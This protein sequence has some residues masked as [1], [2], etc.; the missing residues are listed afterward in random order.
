MAKEVTIQ[1]LDPI[2]F[3]YQSYSEM[4]TELIVQTNVE[5]SFTASTDYIEYYV[6]DQNKNQIFPG[7]TVPLLDFQIRQGDILLDPQT[8]LEGAG[9]DLGIYNILYTFYRKRLGSSVTEKYF[10]SEISSDR[11]E[12][13][14]DSNI[15]DNDLIISSSNEFIEFREASEYFVDFYLNFGNNETVIANNLR[16]ETEEGVDPTVLIKLYD[17]LP[18]NFSV[19]DE[20]WVVEQISTPQAYE[21]DFPFEPIIEEDFTYIAGPNYNLNVTQETSTGGES[22]SFSSLLQSDVTSSI[23]QIKNLLNQKEINININYENYSNFVHFSSAKT[24]LE[25]FYYKVGLIESASNLLVEKYSATGGTINTPSFIASKA[26]VTSEI[27]NIIK[28]FDGYESFLYFNSGSSFSYPKITD[29]PPYQLAPTGSTQALE[30]IGNADPEDPYY[31]GQALSASNFDEN[32]RNYLFNSIPEYLRDDPA[33]QGYELF[34]DMVAQYYDNVWIYTKD[35]SNKFDADNRLEFG[36]SKDLVADAIRDFGVKLYASSFNTN[37]LFTAFLGITPSGSTFPFPNMTGSVVDGSGN[38][39]IPSGFEFVD[40]KISASNDIVP[41]NNVQKQLYKRIYHNIPYLLKTKGTV[42]G[43]RALITSYG[44][45]DTIL[46]INEFGGKDRN[47]SQDYDLKQDVFNYAF[48]TGPSATNYVSSSFSPNPT[49]GLPDGALNS[50]GTVQFRFK[51]APIP[52]ASS[53]VA[54]SDI[55]YSQSLWSTDDGGNIMLEYTGSG[56]V[57]GSYSGSAVNPYDYYGTLKFVPAKGDN[58]S[59]SASIFLP[60][61]NGDWWSVQANVDTNGIGLDTILFA[62]NEIDGKIGF[63]GSDTANG[64]DNSFFRDA[65]KAFLNFTS[66]VTVGGKTYDPF[67]G[68]FQELR[69]FGSPLSESK[70]FDYTV[71]PYSVEG[72]NINST[73]DELI[74][75]AALGTQ[76]DTGSRI[77]IHPRI[78]GSAIQITQSWNGDISSFFTSSAK[79]VTNVEDIFQDQTPAGIKNRINEKIY[80]ENL[81]LAES[82]YGFETLTSSEATISNTSS[83]T[84]S[85]LESIQQTSYISQSYTPNVDYLEVAFSP[86]NQINDDINAQIGYFNLGDYIGDPRFISSSDYSYPNLDRLRDA[87]FEK[88]IRGYDIVDFIRLIKF[89][90]NSLFKMIKDFTPARTSL[91]SGVVVKQHILERNRLRPAQVSSSFHD[92]SGSVVNLPK[93]YSSGSVDFPQYSTSGSALYKFSGGPGGSFNRYN[94]LQSYNFSYFA[95]TSSDIGGAVTTN[96][97]NIPSLTDDFDFFQATG[98]SDLYGDYS[99]TIGSFVFT[100]D[101]GEVNGPID[102]SIG[103]QLPTSTNPLKKAEAG[104]VIIINGSDLEAGGSGQLI[105]TIRP[106]DLTEVNVQSPNNRFNLTQSWSESFDYGSIDRSVIDSLLFNRS[107]SQFISASYKGVRTGVIHSDQSE[108]YNGIFTGSYIEVEDGI[109]NPDCAPYLNVTD[110]PILYKPIFFSISDNLEGVVTRNQFFNQLNY[111][112]PGFA[113]ICSDQTIVGGAFD[114][115]SQVIA[116]KLSQTDLNN[117]EIIDYLS[118]LTSLR[119]ILGDASIPYGEKAVEFDIVG[120]TVYA[121][122]ALL[123]ISTVSGNNILNNVDGIQYYPITG[124][125]NGGS[126]NWSLEAKTSYNTTGIVNT[127]SSDNTQQNVLS[128][129]N[130][131]VQEQNIYFWNNFNSVTDDPLGFFNPGLASINTNEI[132]GIQNLSRGNEFTS[133]AYTIDYTPNIPWFITASIVYSSSLADITGITN[134]T[135]IYH[136]G[137]SYGGA[138]FTNQNFELGANGPQSRDQISFFHI[139]GPYDTAADADTAGQTTPPTSTDTKV[140][141]NTTSNLTPVV[142][143]GQLTNFS[144][145]SLSTELA[146]TRNNPNKFFVLSNLENGLGGA[147]SY[148]VISVY[149]N[150]FVSGNPSQIAATPFGVSNPNTNGNPNVGNLGIISIPPALFRPAPKTVSDLGTVVFQGNV[151]SPSIPGNSGSGIDM[152][153]NAGHPKI[154]LASTASMDWTFP[155]LTLAGTIPTLSAGS[156]DYVM[157]SGSLNKASNPDFVGKFPGISSFSEGT[158]HFNSNTIKFA[159]YNS[160]DPTPEDYFYRPVL[161]AAGTNLPYPTPPRMG[162]QRGGEILIDFAEVAQSIST[163]VTSIVSTTEIT[164]LGLQAQGV[165]MSAIDNSGAID[166]GASFDLRL[167]LYFG[168]RDEEGRLGPYVLFTTSSVNG[169][170]FL[171]ESPFYSITDVWSGLT[172]VGTDYTYL[173]TLVYFTFRNTTS[174]A[175]DI[176]YSLSVDSIGAQFGYENSQVGFGSY[177]SGFNNTNKIYE[178]VST[179]TGGNAYQSGSVASP[180]VQVATVG[181]KYSTAI[182]DIYLKRTGSQGDFIITSSVFDASTNPDGGY[183]GS[184]YNGGTF[185]FLESPITNILHDTEFDITDSST[186]N[187]TQAQVGDIFYIEYSASNFVPG[188]ISGVAPVSQTFN[189]EENSDKSTIQITQSYLAGTPDFNA[190]GSLVV[191]QGNVSNPTSLGSQVENLSF[192]LDPLATAERV[193]LSGSFTGKFN[194]KDVFRFGIRNTKADV[195]LGSGLHVLS[196]TASLAP[197]QSIW[198]PLTTPAAFNNFRDPVD[199]GIIVPTYFPGAI[200][201]DI[202]LGCQP[203]LNNFV[204]QRT[205]PYIMDIDYNY[206]SSTIYYSSSLA[207]V[208]FIQILS[209]S[210]VR[211]AI[212]E[213]NYTILGSINPRYLGAKSTSAKLNVWSSGD[214][215]TYGK[216]PTIELRDAFFGYFNDLDDPYPNINNLTR[217]NLNYLIDEQGNALPPGLNRLSIDTFETVFPNGTVGKLAAKSGNNQYKVLGDSAPISR[218]MEYVTPIMYSQNSGQNYTETIPLSGSGYVFRYDNDNESDKV[219]SSFNVLGTASIDTSV[220]QQSVSFILDPSN[221]LTGKPLNDYIPY[222]S[223]Q[224][225][226]F[227]DPNKY[228]ESVGEDLPNQQIVTVQS[229]VVTSFVSETNR[230]RDELQFTFHL[231]TGSITPR[232]PSS[233]LNENTEI[234]FN[235]EDI[236]CTVYTED[237]RVTKLGSVM[238]YGWFEIANVVNYRKVLTQ[239][240]LQSRNRAWWRRNRWKYTKVPVP[241]GGIKCKVDWEMY[242]T[243]FDLGLMRERNPRG[244]A[245]VLALEWTIFANSGN[246][247][248]KVGDELRWKYTGFFKNSRGGFKQGFFFPLQYPNQYTSINIEGVGAY[249]HLMSTANTASAPFWV[250]TGSSG[251]GSTVL[252]Q[253]F[254]VMSSSNMNE[255]YGQ[256]FRQADLEY[257]PGPSEYF[258]EGIEPKTTRFDNIEYNLELQIGDEIRFANNENFTYTITQVFPPQANDGT[259]DRA[260]RLKIKVDRPVDTSINKDFFLVRRPITNPNSLY[261]ETPFPY[262]SLASASISKEIVAYSGSILDRFALTGS[263]T[264]SVD[265]NVVSYTG[266]FSDLEIAS[267]PGILYPDYPTEYLIQSASIIVNDLITKGIIES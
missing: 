264:G 116:V 187:T 8:T 70:F 60:F 18:D 130:I 64:A 190:T 45:P 194:Y 94:G 171:D 136:S 17:P 22:F 229:S 172:G 101:G 267:T 31:G 97:M 259:P 179:G 249:D 26:S 65:S 140:F 166:T 202:A 90:D 142:V 197:S 215:G 11:T 154:K 30:W 23:N 91:A 254:L 42:A 43:L 163:R 150:P 99:I 156:N 105:L 201:F 9:Y 185:E 10:I 69:Y 233:G 158:T 48:D 165:T 191:R 246:Y 58:P 262:E 28:N 93:D 212:P 174:P 13:R 137:S 35:I 222:T 155:S 129:P 213:S 220:P 133:S 37:D 143:L 81:I 226:T 242:D 98:S 196:V 206:Q 204:R 236:T 44:I 184:I 160:T 173:D 63:S 208:N 205:N 253:Q 186:Y 131:Q 149:N 153:I 225:V 54:S 121:E 3:E 132:L 49:W 82:P 50:P 265:D 52:T 238:E 110:T 255:A 263:L 84:L 120:R 151:F 122:H 188:Q 159:P 89:F 40:T 248:I 161:S 88:Y 53:N 195:G 138:N 214:V 223:S 2:T 108:F 39:S 57:T 92:Y 167:N 237:G 104:D 71:N 4:D 207:P 87:Y 20:L 230:T 33:N 144:D 241:T 157:F 19:K 38:L 112:P 181:D 266:S 12:I 217:V 75:R 211:A 250:F 239:G 72:N 115:T 56:F 124:S 231:Y 234:P 5:T 36:I 100:N 27:D 34:V 218:I 169:Q 76:L 256:S 260:N 47:E 228:S 244:G 210:A 141:Y 135:G 107:S 189:F 7:T 168:D 252:D 78:T 1:L 119:L 106:E 148:L 14:L 96:T 29:S 258:P 15:I 145:E 183:S 59:I 198:A 139:I 200:P 175:R 209:G 257:F 261:L 147:Q 21:L 245:G 180:A 125:T 32:N 77:S 134:D 219:F 95:L 114:G 80:S 41:L 55:R 123:R 178:G 162:D 199:T 113:W 62:A 152:S 193:E 83:N 109:L 216:N 164:D 111:P 251:G 66:P 127:E 117:E 102:I 79:W 221:T 203:L 6:Y 126:A 170:I 227:Y 232:T 192:N 103:A 247:N 176:N 86:T 16:L 61:F 118:E 74:F 85:A 68:S 240:N 128:N 67:S 73:P 51:S 243:L 235:L 146:L 25:N 24:R 182:V 46:R 177:P 224:G